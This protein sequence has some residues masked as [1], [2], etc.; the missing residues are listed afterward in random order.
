MKQFKD[1]YELRDYLAS[2]PEDKWTR[3][4]IAIE[5]P[6]GY[7]CCAMGHIGNYAGLIEDRVKKQGW[8]SPSLEFDEFSIAKQVA[9]FLRQEEINS[10]IK[11]NDG[12]LEN[13][14]L[15]PHLGK[16]DVGNV[17]KRVMKELDCIILERKKEEHV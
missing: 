14:K 3:N 6:G 9:P 16:E 8:I 7:R 13:G 17:K 4:M 1:I 15:I 10:L 5:R 12:R 2:V 11:A